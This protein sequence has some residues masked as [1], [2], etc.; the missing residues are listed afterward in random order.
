ML[1]YVA[2]TCNR[3]RPTEGWVYQLSQLGSMQSEIQDNQATSSPE[4]LTRRAAWEEAHV[5]ASLMAVSDAG[6]RAPIDATPE[7]PSSAP[8]SVPSAVPSALPSALPSAVP[9]AVTSAVPSAVPSAGTTQSDMVQ[10][11]TAAQAAACKPAV[12][13]HL[14]T[15]YNES[16]ENPEEPAAPPSHSETQIIARETDQRRNADE[17]Q[18][19]EQLP[20]QGTSSVGDKGK[21]SAA[22]VAEEH[23]SEAPCH[24]P[25]DGSD[26]PNQPEDHPSQPEDQEGNG[27]VFG[28][29]PT[30]KVPSAFGLH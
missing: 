1:Q 14:A 28:R 15:M 29:V 19:A 12:V 13:N 21:K 4:V 20:G 11:C 7:V 2:N 30:A 6:H 5:H 10:S 24:S 26:R 16:Q 23:I 3:Q 27:R 18:Q 25:I 22:S 17:A 8:S 9:S